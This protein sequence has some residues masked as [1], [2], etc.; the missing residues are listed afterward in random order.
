MRHARSTPRYASSSKSIALR[1]R[2]ISQLEVLG[3]HELTE[4]DRRSLERFFR[5]AESLPLSDTVVQS[6]IG[7]RR[8][9][10]M[11]LGDSIIAGTAIIHKRTLVTRNTDDFRWIEE[12][13]LLDPLVAPG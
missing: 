1:C 12:I 10:K 13:K 2:Y 5:T 8:R 11:S 4:A 3:Y 7:P 9:R 6:A